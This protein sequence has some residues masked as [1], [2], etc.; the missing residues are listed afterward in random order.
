MGSSPLKPVD[1]QLNM[2]MLE[3]QLHILPPPPARFI[4]EQPTCMPQYALPT[5]LR[6]PAG[7]M[8]VELCGDLTNREQVVNIHTF[9]SFSTTVIPSTDAPLSGGGGAGGARGRGPL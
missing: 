8:R 5:L 3:C 6:L 2:P 9:T 1:T 7:H 4:F